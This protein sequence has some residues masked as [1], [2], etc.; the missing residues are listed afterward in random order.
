MRD[1]LII[2]RFDLLTASPFAVRGFILVAM[3]C[4]WM[5]LFYA[6]ITLAFIVF[7][8]LP[9]VLPL[10]GVADRSDFA[11]LYGVI[12]IS[13]RN[14]TRGRFIYIFAVFFL[15][16]LAEIAF[17]VISHTLN[18]S[19]LLPDRNS[20]LMEYVKYAFEK[21][22]TTLL[23]VFVLFTAVCIF[24]AYMEMMVQ[25]FGA[26]NLFRIMT[27]SVLVA[28]GVFAAYCMCEMTGHGIVYSF[29][30][31]YYIVNLLDYLEYTIPFGIALNII[32]LVLCLVFGRITARRLS[33]REL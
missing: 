25:I 3:L 18:L 6:P 24:V 17:A 10:N 33:K 27:A 15:T 1:T 11:K 28:L 2:M 5:G 32:A 13:R 7:G 19:R 16:E 26:E 23:V 20:A 12:P 22:A 14:I 21:E 30:I 8:A 4:V 9:F 31:N 29:G